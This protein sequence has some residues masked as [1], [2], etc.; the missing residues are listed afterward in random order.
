VTLTHLRVRDALEPWSASGATGALRALGPPGGT[1]Y[2]TAG[3]V[4]YAECPL[5]CGVN[6][7]LTA[8]GRLGADI[9]RTALAAGRST[10]RVDVELTRHGLLQR[11]E[12]ESAY[13]AATY[14]AAHF[15]LDARCEV[16]F[17]MGV[18]HP[19][20][21]VLDIDLADVCAEVDRRRQALHDAW[22]DAAVDTS[23]VIPVR[24]PD[25]HHVSL[26]ALQWEIVLNAGRRRTPID[27]ARVLGRDTYATILAVRR[28]VRGGLAVPL[29]D[30]QATVRPAS[31]R[32]KPAGPSAPPAGAAPAKPRRTTT[33]RTLTAKPATNGTTPRAGGTRKNGIRPAPLPRRSEDPSWTAA[34]PVPASFPTTDWSEDTLTR[35]LDALQ[36]L[37]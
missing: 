8:S 13:L 10:G 36:A 9:W 31:A 35:I 32:T 25:G 37:P 17:E 1:V 12:L 30:D 2:L 19:M 28:M 7:L 11:L 23:P 4:S 18:R 5:A 3:R 34:D 22:P 15:L 6:R 33:G 16:R 14:G 20:G 29:P 27:L 21:P 26:T 24:R